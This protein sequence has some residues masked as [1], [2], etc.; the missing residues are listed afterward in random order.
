MAAHF[1]GPG[2]HGAI[3]ISRGRRSF[4]EVRSRAPGWIPGS[5]NLAI[6]LLND[7]GVKAEQA[8]KAGGEA[9]ASNFDEALDLLAGVLERD[10]A[11][12]SRSFLPR[13][14]PRT[15]GASGRGHRHFK[16]V[17]EIDP[18]DAAAWYWT[19]EHIDRPRRTRLGPPAP[20]RP[21]SRSAY[22]T[23]ALELNPYLT[24]A[25]YK[26]A[27]AYVY[28]RTS[29][30]DR[31]SC[32][33][34]GQEDQSRSSR[35]FAWPGRSLAKDYGE[36]GKYAASINPFPQPAVLRL[37]RGRSRR[38]SRPPAARGHASRR[39]AMGQT[40]RLPGPLAVIGRVRARFG[41]AVAA[42]DANGDGQLDLYLASAV[43]G[44]DGAIRDA[45]LLNKGDGRFEDASASFGL[46]K[47][48]A[49]LGVAAADFD[50]DR[51]IDVFPDRR[52]RQPP[53]AQPRRQVVRGYLSTLEVRP[54][55]ACRSWPAGST[56]T[57]MAIST[58]TSSTTARPSTPTRRSSASAIA[59]PGLANTVYRNDGGPIRFPADPSQ[60]RAPV[61]IATANRWSKKGLPLALTPWPTPVLLMAARRPT[62]ASPCSTSTT[63]A[64]STWSRPPTMRRRVAIL[65]DRLGQFHRGH[66]RC[67][68]RGHAARL[69]HS[70]RPTSTPTA[71]PT[72]SPPAANGRVLAWRNAT[73]TNHRADDRADL[74]VV[75]DQ[76]QG[77]ARGPGDRPRPRRPARPAGTARLHRT[78]QATCSCRPGPDNER[79]DSRPRPC[80]FRS[81]A[82]ASRD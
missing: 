37:S 69:G 74:R 47:D 34:A 57:R 35:T 64:T 29:K 80:R 45:L 75:A 50:A 23:K 55:P 68:S 40:V 60:D 46:P 4:R 70:G 81:R 51:H 33:P 71:A 61:A 21:R 16:R 6:A 48:R 53:L 76:R 63:T 20:N 30:Q 54:A 62:P 59:P 38:N 41:A 9:A 31:R 24:P 65:N 49:S 2:T 78:S 26:M 43:I 77:L 15:A 5:I 8:K 58:S 10:P 32:S 79:T 73:E 7:S 25:I 18:N 72:W 82:P 3:R 67:G 12:P 36:M 17:T 14:H 66:A 27:F 39:R 44:P 13:H 22:L 52:R 19:G 11:N 42:F 28:A 1:Q 56:S